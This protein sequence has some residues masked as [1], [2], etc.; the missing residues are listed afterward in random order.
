MVSIDGI[1]RSTA[2]PGGICMTRRTLT[3]LIFAIGVLLLEAHT[4]LAVLW[5]II[6]GSPETYPLSDTLFLYYAQGF[7]PILGAVCLLAA[8]LVYEKLEITK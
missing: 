8:G 7:T 1:E 6:T 2:K 4:A 3:Y 5:Q